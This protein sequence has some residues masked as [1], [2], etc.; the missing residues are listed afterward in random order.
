MEEKIDGYVDIHCHIVPH[1]DDGARSSTQA[2]RMI[3]I[4]YKNGIRAMIATPHYEVGKYDNNIDEIQKQFSKIKDLA[5]KKYRDFKLYLGNEIFYSYGVVNNL[6][7]GKI[8]TLADSKY[9]LVEFSPN[10]KYKYISESLYELVNNGYIPVLAHAERY[11]E[12]IE[13]I[14]NVERLVDAGVYIQINA[15][16]IAGKYGHG[17]R[18]RVMKMI[19][20]DLVHFIGTD[21]HSDGHRSPDLEECIKYLNKKTDEETVV[22]LLSTNPQKII[23]KEYI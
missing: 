19:K 4:A 13:D 12:V 1:I 16:T 22:R 17:I 3:D 6:E 21:T 14:D 11:E 20:N 8:F 23:A 2:L 15:H 10:D 7:E 18:R 9:V 5:L